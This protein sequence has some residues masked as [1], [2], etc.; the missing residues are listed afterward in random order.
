[1]FIKWIFVVVVLMRASTS[2]IDNRR[3]RWWHLILWGTFSYVIFNGG[4]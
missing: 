4:I 2:L 3:F 1:M